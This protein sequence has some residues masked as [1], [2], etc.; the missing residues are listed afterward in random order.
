MC[1]HAAEGRERDIQMPVMN[2]CRAARLIRESADRKK[3]SIP[4][5]ALT[6]NALKEDHDRAAEAGMNGHIAKPLDV[7]RMF[8]AIAE[9][10]STRQSEESYQ[11]CP[12]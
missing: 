6:A 5:L 2:G 9:V 4:I 8:Q 12:Q 3:A 11:A 1:G 7:G 10:L